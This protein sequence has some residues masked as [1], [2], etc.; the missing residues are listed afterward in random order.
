M[1]YLSNCW[2]AAAPK[3]PEQLL[4]QL[5]PGGRMVIPVGP[6]GCQDLKLVMRRDDHFEEVSL[7]A[8]SFVPLVPGQ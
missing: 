5:A 4:Q 8:V 1:P 6:P 3:L 7:G 2:T